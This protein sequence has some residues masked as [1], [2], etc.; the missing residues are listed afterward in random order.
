MV[1]VNLTKGFFEKRAKTTIV[2][3]SLYMCVCVFFLLNLGILG[4][5][6]F[7]SHSENILQDDPSN[8]QFHDNRN[9]VA[10]STYV[11]H[12]LRTEATTIQRGVEAK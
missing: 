6:K 1:F 5:E 10:T 11:F 4:K 8:D 7:T 12:S 2:Y 9:V 3:A